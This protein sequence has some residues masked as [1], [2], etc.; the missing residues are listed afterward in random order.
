MMD[1][2]TMRKNIESTKTSTRGLVKEEYLVI[3]LRYFVLFLHKN[4]RSH[5]WSLSEALLTRATAQRVMNTP[6][7]AIS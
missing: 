4:V 7:S 1:F 5:K 6:A 2:S 3:I